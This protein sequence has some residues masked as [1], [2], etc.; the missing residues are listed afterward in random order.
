MTVMTRNVADFAATGV[1]TLNPWS[2][3][4]APAGSAPRARRSRR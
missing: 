4:P 2:V 1:G 3:P